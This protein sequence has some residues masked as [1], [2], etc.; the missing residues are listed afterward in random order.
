MAFLRREGK[1][2]AVPR[3]DLIFLDLNSFT[4]MIEQSLQLGTVPTASGSLLAEDSFAS[5]RL[6]SGG[7][8]CRV[9]FVGRNACVADEHGCGKVS[10]TTLSLQYVFATP[11]AGLWICLQI[12]A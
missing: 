12:I 2:D 1:Y 11:I 8:C 5:S 3:P 9:L 7:L 10:S 6:Q 4:E